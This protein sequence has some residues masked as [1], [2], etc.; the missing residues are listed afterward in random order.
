MHIKSTVMATVLGALTCT[1]GAT[2][3]QYD[4][5]F[6]GRVYAPT[7]YPQFAQLAQWFETSGYLT[8]LASDLNRRYVLPKSVQVA[9]NECGAVNAFFRPNV[10]PPT[11]IL[12]YEIVATMSREFQQDRLTPTQME[13]AIRGTIDF[14][15]YHEIGHAL[16]SV[17]S[18]PTTGR[19][20]DVADQFATL[21]LAW[22]N[23]DAAL[24]AARFFRELKDPGNLGFR[25][26]MPITANEFAN[27]HSLDEQ[28]F[29]N[30]LCW[31]YGASP[32]N[33]GGLARYLPRQ[34]AVRCPAEYQ[35]LSNAWR[36]LLASYVRPSAQRYSNSTPPPPAPQSPPSPRPSAVSWLSGQWRYSEQ[37]QQPSNGMT[38]DDTGTILLQGGAGSYEQTGTCMLN[39]QRIDNPGRG[40]LTNVSVDGTTVRFRMETCDYAGTLVRSSPPRIEGTLYCLTPSEGTTIEARGTWAAER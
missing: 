30:I 37:I 36:T 16:V 9:A 20:E 23:P 10:N 11:V 21:M 26:L 40:A 38:C 34:R 14:I 12:C 35:Q 24:W 28:R 18:L 32:G 3:Q 15:T 2:G 6:F 22:D 4:S 13:S 27:E 19:E 1:A 31:T 7:R 29:Y 39:G 33:R 5:G 17:L 8:R 25:R